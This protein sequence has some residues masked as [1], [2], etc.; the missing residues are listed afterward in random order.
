[1]G[2]LRNYHIEPE[3][4]ACCCEVDPRCGGIIA[5]HIKCPEHGA[6]TKPQDLIKTHFHR[7]QTRGRAVGTKAG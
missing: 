5:V 2:G 3:S 7:V 4:E 6:G 1:M